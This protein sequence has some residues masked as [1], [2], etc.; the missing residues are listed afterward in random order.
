MTPP[1]LATHWAIKYLAIALF[2]ASFA[3]F[4]LFVT[5]I[6]LSDLQLD[7][8]SL[9]AAGIDLNH[10]TNPYANSVADNPRQWDGF[11]PLQTSRYLYPPLAGSLFQL[12]AL[13]SYSTAKEVWTAFIVF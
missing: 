11:H 7:F 12:L 4:L 6:V 10:G 2:V 5:G 13:L 8:A 3:H 1:P 9:Y